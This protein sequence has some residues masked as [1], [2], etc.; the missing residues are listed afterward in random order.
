MIN[1]IRYL[2]A[3]GFYLISTA[4]LAI[5]SAPP[6]G[7]SHGELIRVTTGL[8]AV[9][10][11]IVFL[12]WLVK[13]LNIVNLG[14]SHGFQ[15]IATMPIGP[16]EKIILVKIGG[17]YLLMGV[18]AGAINLLYDF[19]NQLPEGFDS[20]DKPAFTEILKLAVRKSKK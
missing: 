13:R 2:I 10:L 20:S 4:T 3:L 11:L 14:F 19:G 16:K 7:I 5:P 15:S 17:R 1:K 8:G 18:G 6:T 12:S 9:L